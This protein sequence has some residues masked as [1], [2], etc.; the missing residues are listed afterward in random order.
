MLSRPFL[1]VPEEPV[2]DDK[3]IRWLIGKPEGA[4]NF[5]MRVIEFQPGAVFETHQHPYEHEI[6]VFEGQGAV[7]GPDGEMEMRIVEVGLMDLVNAE[8]ISGLELG[9]I[10]SIGVEESTETVVPEQEMMIPG[11]GMPMMGGGGPPGGP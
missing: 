4:P 6:F 9:E 3:S 5:A 11:G 7:T 1:T 10:V 2:G 8:I